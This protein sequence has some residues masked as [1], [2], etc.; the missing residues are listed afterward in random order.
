MIWGK[1]DKRFKR[2][3]AHLGGSVVEH[4]PLVQ[5][6]V[7]RS[8][9]QVPHWAPHKEPASL[10]VYVSASFPLFVSLMNK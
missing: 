9:D 6:V 1:S 2:S 4:M 5:V 7:S 3:G 10:S 8:Y